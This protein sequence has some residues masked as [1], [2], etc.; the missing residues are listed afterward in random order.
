MPTS[1]VL[2][3]RFKNVDPQFELYALKIF[4]TLNNEWENT[5]S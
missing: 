3:T 5:F 2:L 1:Y 4:A